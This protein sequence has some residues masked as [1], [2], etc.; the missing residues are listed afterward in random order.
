MAFWQR[1]P[2]LDLLLLAVLLAVAALI[3]RRGRIEIPDALLAGFLGCALGPSG[4]DLLPFDPEGLELIVYHLFAVVFIAQSLCA[5]SRERTGETRSVALALPTLCVIQLLVG[6]AVVALFMG[7]SDPVHPGFGLLMMIGFLQGPGQAV[8]LGSAWEAQGLAQGS[9]LGLVFAAIGFVMCGLV[10][11]PLVMLARKLGWDDTTSRVAAVREPEPARDVGSANAKQSVDGLAFQI[12]AIACVYAATWL[13]L[14]GAQALL[15]DGNPVAATLWGFHFIIGA[16]IGLSARRAIG[17]L[18]LG[19][20]EHLQNRISAIAV[21]F[22]TAGALA[23]VQIAVLSRWL[24]PI[25]IA[26]F[27][28]A[29]LSLWFCV[30][31]ARRAFTTDRFGHAL[32]LLG[33]AT[34]TLA[35]GLALLRMVDPHHRGTATRNAVMGTAASIIPMS[36][37]ILGFLPLAVWLWSFGTATAIAVSATILVG[38]LGVLIVAWHRLT[39][40]RAIPPHLHPWPADHRSSSG[41][42]VERA[43]RER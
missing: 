10:G 30:W 42:H 21:D 18:R 33:A 4:L 31:I 32:V 13:F 28:G 38:Y 11:I 7:G 27:A 1:G 8:A 34:G 40:I 15:P 29:L 22:T 20:D 3:R 23:A 36:P 25:L 6:L 43:R 17:P 5:P 26:S 12:L 39:P 19:I 24:S 35:T 41:A 14:L 9:E 37:L 16:V 2:I